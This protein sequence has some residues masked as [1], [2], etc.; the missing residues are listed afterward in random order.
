VII[1]VKPFEYMKDW[2]WRPASS[3]QIRPSTVCAV[4]VESEKKLALIL[5]PR[6]DHPS[7]ADKL[8]GTPAL[9]VLIERRR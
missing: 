9:L 5:E 7:V 1:S 4:R 6:R 2:N 8:L 3:S